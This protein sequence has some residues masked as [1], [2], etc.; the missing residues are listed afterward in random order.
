MGASGLIKFAIISGLI[1][2]FFGAI[3][4]QVGNFAEGGQIPTITGRRVTD[5]QNIPTQPSGDNVLAMVKRGEMVLND[6]HQRRLFQYAG[7]DIFRRIGVR[8]FADGGFVGGTPQILNPNV[9]VSVPGASQGGADEATFQKFALLIGRE[10]AA[11]V[12][13]A[14]EAGFMSAEEKTDRRRQLRNDTN[15]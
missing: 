4:S 7:P 13:P 15:V 14:V 12:G 9:S 11:Q 3:K 2:G 8:G 6:D 10:V 5:A 1:K